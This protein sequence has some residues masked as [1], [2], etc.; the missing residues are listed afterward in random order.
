MTWQIALFI[1]GAISFNTILFLVAV[2]VFLKPKSRVLTKKERKV[3]KFFKKI[4]AFLRKRFFYIF[5]LAVLVTGYFVATNFL[6][7]NIKDK[8]FRFPEV[9]QPNGL[10]L[11]FYADQYPDWE[12]F[13]ADI[14]S[15]MTGLKKIT[16]WSDYSNYNI[17]K[18]FP[19]GRSICGIK[20]ENERKSSLRCDDKINQY[21][22][23]IPVD[24]FKLI[25]LSRQDF[26][27]WANVA[28]LQNSGIFFSLKNAITVQDSGAQTILFAHL[29]GHAFGLKDEE[30]YV[31]A[32]AGS[33]PHTPDGP[34]CAPDKTTAELWWGDLISTNNEVGYFQ[35]C[36]GNENYIKPTDSSLMNLNNGFENFSPTYGA[37][38]ERYLR[39]ILS[40]CFSPTKIKYE[41]DPDF[42]DRYEEFKRC[43]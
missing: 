24:Q 13:D 14:E 37:V 4:S 41:N 7:L 29:V 2:F 34:N 32:K 28:R 38:S 9:V 23:N 20:T 10:N 36:C 22:E 11:I 26:Q 12:E 43:L 33:A 3:G 18:I 17:Y 42:F 27:S 16:P 8:D 31:L 30:K 1:I 35:T 39:K 5:T 21:L 19:T 6:L 15:L 40:Y 25:V